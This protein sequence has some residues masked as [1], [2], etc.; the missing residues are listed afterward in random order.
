M[1]SLGVSSRPRMAS[2]VDLPQPDG[3][4]IDTYS[5]FLMSR[6]IPAR[7]WVSTSSVR[8]TLVTPSR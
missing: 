8:N 4:E 7:A 2:S 3:P 5:P 6:W 1:P